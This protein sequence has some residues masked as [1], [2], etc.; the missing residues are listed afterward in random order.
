MTWTDAEPMPAEGELLANFLAGQSADGPSDTL[1]VLLQQ[2]R[3]LLD[4]AGLRGAAMVLDHA[5]HGNYLG[6]QS[7]LTEDGAAGH[8]LRADH[9]ALFMHVAAV[10]ATLTLLGAAA[11]APELWPSDVGRG[12]FLQRAVALTEGVA[13]AAVAA[14]G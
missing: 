7:T 2:A 4:V 1:S 8:E 12:P 3:T 13:Q 9:E 11:T 6:F 5:G 14:T 10:G